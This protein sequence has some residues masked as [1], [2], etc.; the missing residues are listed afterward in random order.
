M[1]GRN[2][3]AATTGGAEVEEG[4][5][6]NGGIRGVRLGEAVEISSENTGPGSRSG[7]GSG[8][9]GHDDGGNKKRRR[10]NYHRHTADQIRVMEA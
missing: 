9:E 3:P 7:D 2:A 1:F 10:K 5:E 6:G 4:D 8:E